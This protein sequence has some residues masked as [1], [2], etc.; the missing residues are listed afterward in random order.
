MTQDWRK[1]FCDR[2]TKQSNAK[3]VWIWQNSGQNSTENSV[4]EGTTM[5]FLNM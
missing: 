4:R 3:S 1:D 5:R 2:S